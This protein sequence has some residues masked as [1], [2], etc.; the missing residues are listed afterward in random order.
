MSHEGA[1]YTITMENGADNLQEII[2]LYNAHHNEMRENL[3]KNGLDIKPYNPWYSEYE[4]GW[5]GGWLLN[6]VARHE[7]KAVGYT[8]IYVT[9]DMNNQE[10]I[11]QENNLFVLPEH[12]KGIGRKLFK[13]AIE[14]VRNRGAKR[15]V[16]SAATDPRIVKLWKRMGAKEVAICMAISL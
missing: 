13:F 2:P 10:L 15:L 1:I 7:G 16:M 9:T 11:A 3:R 14:E 6:F 12:R 8:N 4:K 5:R